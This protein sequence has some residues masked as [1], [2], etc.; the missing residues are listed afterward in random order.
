MISSPVPGRGGS[1]IPTA[2]VSGHSGSLPRTRGDGNRLDHIVVGELLEDIHAL[3][4]LAKGD[5][6]VAE[7]LRLVGGGDEE[8]RAGAVRRSGVGHRDGSRAVVRRKRV[9]VLNRMARNV[10][11]VVR[12]IPRNRATLNQRELRRGASGI[13][14]AWLAWRLHAPEVR[15]VIPLRLRQEDEV[16]DRYRGVFGVKLEDDIALC[17]RDR[18]DIGIAGVDGHW[19]RAG[20]RVGGEIAAG[21]SYG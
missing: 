2:T 11:P 21:L 7:E 13:D 20:T 10:N 17:R 3:S 9:I 4:D 19:G 14:H 8:L 5:I 15:A 6:G 12:A 18:S 16:I 1:A